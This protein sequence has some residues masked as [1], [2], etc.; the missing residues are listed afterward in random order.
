MSVISTHGSLGNPLYFVKLIPKG[1]KGVRVDLTGRVESF[2]F[3]DNESK[4]DKLKLTVDNWDLANLDT[5][6]WRKGGILEVT[7]GYPGRLAPARQV[8]I[9]KVTGFTTLKVEGFSKKFLMDRIDRCRVFENKKRSDMVKQIAEEN[10]FSDDV[11]FIQDTKEVVEFQ[12]QAKQTDAHFI[13]RLAQKEGFEFYVDFDGL[14]FH[15]RQVGQKP[16]RT[17]R[18]Y[19]GGASPG[20]REASILSFDIDNDT[21]PIPGR[22]TTRGRDHKKKI[23]F[24]FVVDYTR[25]FSP[26]LAPNAEV[27]A[28]LL[29]GLGNVARDVIDVTAETIASLSLRR[30][31]GRGKKRRHLTVKAKM[32][33]LGDPELLAKTVLGIEGIGNRLSG[34]YYLKKIVHKIAG[35]GYECQCEILRDGHKENRNQERLFAFIPGGRGGGGASTCLSALKNV[36]ARIDEFVDTRDQVFIEIHKKGLGIGGDLSQFLGSRIRILKELQPKLTE[37][38]KSNTLTIPVVDDVQNTAIEIF[39]NGTLKASAGGRLGLGRIGFAAHDL[40]ISASRAKRICIAE[41]AERAGQ[42]NNQTE[43]NRRGAGNQQT[44]AERLERKRLEAFRTSQREGD[45]EFLKYRDRRK[46]EVG[47]LRESLGDGD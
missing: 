23:D 40:S 14:H 36:Q 45:R 31:R 18:W 15:E 34:N 19:A 44:E 4:A 5:P 24:E 16:V 33:I 3:E 22:S 30:A 13:R 26:Q 9:K 35:S 10:G 41:E 25:D 37:D 32:G 7:W 2:E 6:V 43:S 20:N 47:A 38:P 11:Q 46:R 8:V 17:F 21:S 12:T 27:T 42:F 1:T 28:E 39:N 29:T